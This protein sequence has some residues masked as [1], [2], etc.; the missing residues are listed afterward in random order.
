MREPL[1]CHD[2]GEVIGVYE[3]LVT[4]VDGHARELSRAADPH[5]TARDGE[6]LHRACFEQRRIDAESGER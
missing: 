1:H 6:C 4:L 3:P 5:V 2:C